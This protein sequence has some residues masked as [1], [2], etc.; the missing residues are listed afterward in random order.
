MFFPPLLFRRQ[1]RPDSEALFM[2]K[3][4]LLIFAGKSLPLFP[5]DV[6]NPQK[7]SCARFCFCG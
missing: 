4:T 6:N 1:S 7:T 3:K 2:K 5:R